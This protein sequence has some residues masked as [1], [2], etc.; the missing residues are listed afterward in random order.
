MTTIST[1]NSTRG[2]DSAEV[3][4]VCDR[5]ILMSKIH[6]NKTLIKKAISNYNIGLHSVITR[7]G[8]E[9]PIILNK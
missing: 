7:A 6:G 8:D 5:L 9:L 3:S 4:L 2:Y 1:G